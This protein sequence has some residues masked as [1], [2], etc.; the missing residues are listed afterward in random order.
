[1]NLTIAKREIGN[2]S[3]IKRLERVAFSNQIYDFSELYG[4]QEYEERSLKYKF[5][6]G[7]GSYFEPF[8]IFESEVINWIMGV[9]D[10]VILKD[11][12]IPGY[13]FLAEVVNDPTNEHLFAGGTL[14]VEF[15]AYPFKIGDLEEGNDIW[16]DFNFLLDV[17]QETEFEVNSSKE[18]TLY[19]PGASTLRPAINAA[20]S[21]KIIKGNTT[22]NVPAGRSQSYD[23]HLDTGENPIMITGN[24]TISFHFHKE[25]I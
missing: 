7:F 17:A 1:M 5:N 22:F 25:M 15:T 6:I 18:V 20:A 9:N 23:F 21:M 2:P 24:G 14:E 13:Y 11:D 16:D 10:K 19:N 3:K 8:Y 12:F 4:M